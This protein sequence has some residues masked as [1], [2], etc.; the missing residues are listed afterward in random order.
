MKG[1]KKMKKKA[2]ILSLTSALM[3]GTV[4][5]VLLGT[6]NPDLF[7]VKSED[8]F[9]SISFDALDL[10]GELGG[11]FKSDNVVLKTDQN[12]NNVTFHY[13]Q[14]YAYEFSGTNYLEVKPNGY[15]A[16]TT[17]LRGMLS[18]RV[19]VYAQCKVEW[20]FVKVGDEVQYESSVEFYESNSYHEIDFE[21]TKP[22]YFKITNVDTVNRQFTNFTIKMDKECKSSVS[23]YAVA[24]GVKYVKNDTY[25]EAVGFVGS[26]LSTLNIVSEVGGLPVTKIR[27]EAFKGDEAITSL[28]LP[29][30]L[31]EIG[32]QAFKNCT[33]IGAISIPKS[34]RTIG[35]QAFENTSGCSSLTFESGGTETLSLGI[36]AFEANGHSGTLTLPSRISGIS[37]DGYVFNAMQGVTNFALNSDNNEYNILSVEDGVLFAHM[38]NYSHYQKVLV[39][40]PRANTRTVYTIPS[41]CTRVM[42]QDGIGHAY[43][44]EKL[45]IDNDVELYFDSH[46]AVSLAN[47]EEIEFKES[48]YKVYLYWYCLNYAPK[49]YGIEAP[50]NLCVLDRGLY[51]VNNAGFNVFVHGSSIPESWTSSWSGGDYESGKIKVYYHDET[52]PATDNEKLVTWHYVDGVPTPY[53][54]EV[55]FYC[56]RTDI[57]DGYAFY[58]LGVD[59]WTASEANRGS[60]NSDYG[61]WEVTLTMTPNQPYSFKG[62]IS[63]WDNPTS[64]SYEEG[65]NRSWTPDRFSKEY[66]VD[67]HY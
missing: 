14:C 26:S 51:G 29:N 11:D 12:K 55:L 43:N 63:T 40:Y 4:S 31:I 35:G 34:V 27:E 9:W 57:G 52:E 67:W 38:A 42:N 58:V 10:V 46:S 17:E 8:D 6:K 5:A 23:P 41:D 44:I 13:D 65:S 60:Y 16:N 7:G 54:I 15:V 37:F 48:E 24:N 45:I 53:A 28:T 66:G 36:A 20:G 21:G 62:A 59:S 3:L 47:L 32:E 61:R 19:M 1:N 2:L 30:S 22:N 18:L 56:Y 33:K 50:E 49:L 39:S 25:A 64:I